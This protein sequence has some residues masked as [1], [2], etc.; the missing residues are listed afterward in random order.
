MAD[1]GELAGS[2]RTV[3]DSEY[4][5][6]YEYRTALHGF[7]NERPYDSSY[8]ELNTESGGIGN[9]WHIQSWFDHQPT[10][11][12]RDEFGR[13]VEVSLHPTNY[14]CIT[15]CNNGTD[16]ELEHPTP[17]QSEVNE[18]ND[19]NDSLQIVDAGVALSIGPV[20]FG[21]SGSGSSGDV[22]LGGLHDIWWDLNLSSTYDWPTAQND[23][24]G[25]RHDAAPRNQPAGERL[26]FEGAS[27][28]GY[29]FLEGRGFN[30]RSTPDLTYFFSA[31]TF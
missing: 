30:R 13:E 1:S 6:S 10:A 8:D 15:E 20:S 7:D 21:I 17:S 23:A 12:S 3:T 2:T 19:Y 4:E 22:D 11:T 9:R 31:T 5:Y 18:N 26:W 24:I 25:T 16:A 29:R 27:E 28:F 14:Y